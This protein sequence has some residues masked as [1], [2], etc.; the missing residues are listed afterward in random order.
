MYIVV[1][2]TKAHYLASI[3]RI[4]KCNLV[5]IILKKKPSF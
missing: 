3:E 5:P 2:K 1:A 4:A